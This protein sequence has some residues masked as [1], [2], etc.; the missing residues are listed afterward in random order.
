[1]DNNNSQRGTTLLKGHNNESNCVHI[2][3]EELRMAPF[4]T[5][6]PTNPDANNGLITSIWGPHE[7]ESF[8]AKTFG[9]PINP[10]DQQK[11][12]YMNYFINL[13]KVL[14][15][16]YCRLSYQKFINED[17]T[18]LDMSVME[19]RET[20]TK[21]AMRL[22]NRVNKKLG[23]DYGDTYE[24]LCYK[25]ESY[26]ARCSKSSKGCIM[27]LSMKAK[28][29]QKADIHRAPI[30]DKKYSFGLV[31]YAKSQ[32]LQNYEEFLSYYS[33]LTR[34]SEEWSERDCTARRIIKFMR[35]NG[36]SSLTKE[37]LPSVHEMVLISMMSSTLESE[38]LDEIL[39]KVSSNNL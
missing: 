37:G 19:S 3:P 39:Q 5:N 7:W 14:P 26:R 35:K 12:D 6:D 15:C 21:W 30:I 10:S 9:Y 13:G 16:E 17:D 34:N 11:Y 18:M 32:G 28:S 1:M 22:H 33:S 8:H 24:E 23:V 4:K 36:V 31:G 2:D 29:F 27:P 38:K 20:L 25:Y